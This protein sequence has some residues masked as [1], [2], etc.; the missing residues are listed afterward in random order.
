METIRIGNQRAVYLLTFLFLLFQLLGCET[1]T[2]S[3]SSSSTR[4]TTAAE[5]VV[6]SA[7]TTTDVDG[8]RTVVTEDRPVTDR[9]VVTERNTTTEERDPGMGGP[10]HIVGEVLAFPFRLVGDLFDG[11]F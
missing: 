10:F 1:S 8:D 4:T 11:I 9:T 3:T 2:H 7:T 5:P 6:H